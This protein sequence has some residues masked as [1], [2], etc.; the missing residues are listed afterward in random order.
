[1]KDGEHLLIVG[2]HVRTEARNAMLWRV[3]RQVLEQQTADAASLVCVD[4]SE[5][6]LRGATGA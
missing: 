1:M 5:R 6:D 3:R 2:E 4:D